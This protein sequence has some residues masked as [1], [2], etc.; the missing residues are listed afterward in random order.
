MLIKQCVI[1]FSVSPFNWIFFVVWVLMSSF[2]HIT[3]IQQWRSILLRDLSFYV[4]MDKQ[5]YN[6]ICCIGSKYSLVWR[7]S[8]LSCQGFIT[9]L[10]KFFFYELL[11]TFPLPLTLLERCDGCKG[12][13]SW[14]CVVPKIEPCNKSLM[15]T[16]SKFYPRCGFHLIEA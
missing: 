6:T 16:I 12:F 10:C 4:S 15:C 2:L 3:L 9:Y 14:T 5:D 8:Q 1:D 7:D 11:S 13:I